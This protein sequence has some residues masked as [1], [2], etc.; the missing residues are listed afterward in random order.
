VCVNG[1][2]WD[3]LIPVMPIFAAFWRDF[4]QTNLNFH[5]HVSRYVGA[6]IFPTNLIMIFFLAF[7]GCF[8]KLESLGN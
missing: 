3:F 2:P 8:V 7:W 6:G 1:Q 4:H 5:T